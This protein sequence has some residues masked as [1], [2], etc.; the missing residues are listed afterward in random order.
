MHL[1]ASDAQAILDLL[2]DVDSTGADEPF[3]AEF[4][5]RLRDVVACV[6]LTY[7]DADVEARRFIATMPEEQSEED[8]AVYWAVGPCP[9]SKYRARTGD[10]RTLAMSDVISRRQYHELPLYREYFQ[11]V[12]LDHVLDVGLSMAAPRL[13]SLVFLRA[14]GDPDFS[15]RDRHVLDALRPHLRAREARAELWQRAQAGSQL[16]ISPAG[17][18]EPLTPRER[19]VIYLA[20]QGKSNAEIASVLWVTPGTVKKHLENIYGKLDVGSRAAAVSQLPAEFPGELSRRRSCARG[21]PRWPLAPHP[22]ADHRRS[23]RLRASCSTATTK[24]RPV[25]DRPGLGRAGEG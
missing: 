6:E 22:A 14:A 16:D 3:S 18:H 1:V 13:R 24:P 10:L 9:I 11:P 4:L 20:G 5:A 19:E 2:A 17:L 21:A 23:V 8:D 7:Q 15:D 12:G 25:S